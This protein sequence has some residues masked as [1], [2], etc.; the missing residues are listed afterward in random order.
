MTNTESPL[1]IMR[2]VI[3][4]LDGS[5]RLALTTYLTGT[6]DP[7]LDYLVDFPGGGDKFSQDF[8]DICKLATPLLPA[9]KIFLA[10]ELL[11]AQPGE[12]SLST[13]SPTFLKKAATLDQHQRL[14]LATYLTGTANS[15][16]QYL[17]KLPD[18]DKLSSKLTDA[19]ELSGLL[20]PTAK[21]FFAIKL[22]SEPGLLGKYD[23]DCDIDSLP[24]RAGLV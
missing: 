15:K 3:A 10:I 1:I 14:A 13:I 17:I 20:L 4:K 18:Y 12:N 24:N 19:C 21:I 6:A 11:E 8:V 16:F 23:G 22:L 7:R 9:T 2:N 5:E